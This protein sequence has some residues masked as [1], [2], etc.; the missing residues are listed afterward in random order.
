M[1]ALDKLDLLFLVGQ[2]V[3]PIIRLLPVIVKL[4]PELL[5]ISP[6]IQLGKV[7]P[8]ISTS[9]EADTQLAQRLA[10][11]LK[12]RKKKDF[13]DNAHV[14]KV[15]DV[16]ECL[17]KHFGEGNLLKDIA[18]GLCNT[19]AGKAETDPNKTGGGIAGNAIMDCVREKVLK[20]TSAR[21]R[22]TYRYSKRAI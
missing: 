19:I 11:K 2:S 1:S 16:R 15:S 5:K 3:A 12:L 14:V 8:I 13:N 18:L 21:K 22:L 17:E 6:R 9:P 4:F 20:Q 10:Q 7:I